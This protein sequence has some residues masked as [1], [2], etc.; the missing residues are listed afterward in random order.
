MER[1]ALL[2]RVAGAT[3]AG[4]LA[5]CLSTPGPGSGDPKET[6]DPTTDPGT[7]PDGSRPLVEELTVGSRDGVAFPDNHLPH[8]LEVVNDAEETREVGLRLTSSEGSAMVDETWSF[9]AGG[10]VKMRLLQPDAYT[11]AVT[12]AEGQVGTV[13]ISRA[14]FDCNDSRTTVDVKADGTLDVTTLSTELACPAPE[15]TETTLSVTES[16]CADEAD[17]SATVDTSEE[18]ITV[19]GTIRVPNPCYGATLERVTYGER[20]DDTLSVRV[21]QTEPDGDKVCVECVGAVKYEAAIS[22]ANDYPGTVVVEHEHFGR[23]DEV[24][25]VQIEE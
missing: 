8:E 20:P 17:G 24:A 23:V 15:V 5:G 16:G 7:T 19:D 1:R 18:A 9:P 22:V 14:F 2:K 10:R 11:L 3:M 6:N 13:S 21:A 4:G 12:L 25:R